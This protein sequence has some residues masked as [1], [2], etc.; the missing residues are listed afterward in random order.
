MLAGDAGS[1]GRAG[2]SCGLLKDTGREEAGLGLWLPATGF[3]DVSGCR[4]MTGIG[5]LW[6]SCLSPGGGL[7]GGIGLYSDTDAGL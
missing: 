5:G 1:S 7:G 2:G 6:N 4:K 3:F